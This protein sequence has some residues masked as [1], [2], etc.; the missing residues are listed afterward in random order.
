VE[1]ELSRGGGRCGSVFPKFVVPCRQQSE[2]TVLGT[3]T[4]CC[5]RPRPPPAR[6]AAAASKMSNSSAN[7]T[8]GLSDGS[9]D[10]TVINILTYIFLCVVTFGIGSAVH[11]SSL[12]EVWQQRKLCLL[13]GLL[14]QYLIMPAVARLIVVGVM[15]LPAM[16]AFGFILI[17]CCPGGAASN[18][19]AYFAKADMALSVSMTATTNFLAFGTLPLFL[20]LWTRGLGATVAS[21]TIPF[22]DIFGSLCM[23]LV[24]AA[25]GVTLRVKQPTWAGRAEK[26]GA[27]SGAVLIASSIL[28]GLLQNRQTLQDAEL[29][30]WRNAVA[31]IVVA[32]IGMIFASLAVCFI[33]SSPCQGRLIPGRL[34]LSCAATIVM[35]TG[36]QNTV[37]ALAMTTL[38]SRGWDAD[39]AFRLNMIPILWGGCVSVE[40]FFVML[41]FRHLISREEAQAVAGG[42]QSTA[43]GAELKAAR[44]AR[45]EYLSR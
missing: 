19:F 12:R 10:L 36:I 21:N 32:P 34:P 26:V 4:P 41:L 33:N 9:T 3:D 7:S 16:D 45:P 2:R 44:A 1:P 25:L 28:V 14:A 30:P 6:R 29:I 43:G 11:L 13:I 37:L 24:P 39:A 31:A 27:I 23:V 20:F 8:G 15:G 38:T 42:S 35:E 22:L 40:A 18:A 17:G 5:S